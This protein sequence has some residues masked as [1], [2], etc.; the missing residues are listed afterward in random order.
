[1]AVAELPTIADARVSRGVRGVFIAN[2]V[3]QSA[4][5][6]TGA[7]VRVTASGLGC[8]T[9][10]ECAPG[11][12]IPTAQQVE[13]WQ[14]FVEFGNR[15]LTFALAALAIAA[16]VAIIRQRRQWRAAGLATRPALLVLAAIPLLG[17]IVQAVLGGITVLTGLHPATVSA[18]FLVSMA[19]IA[20]VVALVARSADPG[21]GHVTLLVP[22]LVRLLGWG[23]LAATAVVVFLGVLVTGTGPHSG[24]VGVDARFGFD[25]QMISWL[26]ADAVW[27]FLGLLIGLL[28]ALSIA[29][30][31]PRARR[32]AVLLLIV[33]SV[34]GII[35]YTQ[36]F[37]GLPEVLVIFHVIGAVLIW[38]IALFLP[39]GLRER[40]P[41][42][43]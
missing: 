23:V 40:Q 35:G 26:H 38:N 17:T 20:A 12:L 18:H 10:P 32:R 7:I 5:V 36:F 37:T 27:L 25:F 31:A 11:S 6:V 13:S 24:D 8:P 16:V 33:A 21:D 28:I 14:K 3:A 19:I 29:G 1:M 34:Q 43:Q 2:L 4:I 39:F 41:I 30:N 15:L 42:S 9:W 22:R